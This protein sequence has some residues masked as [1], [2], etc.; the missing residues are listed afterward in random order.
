MT[1]N[2]NYF[3]S[4]IVF[5][6]STLIYSCFFMLYCVLRSRNQRIQRM[7]T[8]KSNEKLTNEKQYQE[9]QE[10]QELQELQEP[11]EPE[12]ILV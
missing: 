10:L 9:P 5:G 11:Q 6:Y 3:L 12:F 7:L 4:A 8:I 1:M 2:L